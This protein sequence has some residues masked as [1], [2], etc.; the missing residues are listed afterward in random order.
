MKLP[1]EPDYDGG[2]FMH[3]DLN[4]EQLQAGPVVEW[5]PGVLML[6]DTPDDGGT[7]QCIPG[8][9]RVLQDW[10]ASVDSH[11]LCRVATVQQC[12]TWMP[13]RWPASK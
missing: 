5:C 12:Q 13:P 11:T 8:F 6:A 9:H 3:W 4:E 7:F 2:D 10:V 1:D